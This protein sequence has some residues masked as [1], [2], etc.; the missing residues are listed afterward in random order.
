[1]VASV[2]ARAHLGTPP[3]GY[4]SCSLGHASQHA[5]LR[6]SLNYA[7]HGKA[8]RSQWNVEEQHTSIIAPTNCAVL[9]PL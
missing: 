8:P 5:V 4:R 7:L 2:Q 1:M 9:P 6:C 3:H